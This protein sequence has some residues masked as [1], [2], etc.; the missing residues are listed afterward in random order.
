MVSKQDA[1]G[2][3]Q[4]PSA[5]TVLKKSG[6]VAWGHPRR[7]RAKHLR[8]LEKRHPNRWLRLKLKTLLEE[9]LS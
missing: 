5:M 1:D 7:R 8:L 9:V 2:L 6:P 3:M 4:Q